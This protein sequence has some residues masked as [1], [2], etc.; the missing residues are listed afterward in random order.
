MSSRGSISAPSICHPA[1]TL[2]KYRDQL[3]TNHETIIHEPKRT[4]AVLIQVTTYHVLNLSCHHHI[5]SIGSFISTSQAY[6][7]CMQKPVNPS[8][9]L[10]PW[11]LL[12]DYN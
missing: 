6:G 5:A 11:L 1:E 8:D 10:Y 3:P 9:W 4:H 12:V 7:F 2:A